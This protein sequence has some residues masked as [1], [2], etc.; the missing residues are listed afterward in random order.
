MSI[1]NDDIIQFNSTTIMN[2]DDE[3]NLSNSWIWK[4]NTTYRINSNR[5]HSHTYTHL[6]CQPKLSIHLSFIIKTF[7]TLMMIM[8]QLYN[9][10]NNCWSNDNHLFFWPIFNRFSIEEKRKEKSWKKSFLRLTFLS[11]V[12]MMIVWK[13]IKVAL[14]VV[15]VSYFA[16]HP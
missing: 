12:M 5:T 9:Q 10:N 1:S 11:M 16:I 6:N 3:F 7:I 14:V 2:D 8:Y 13:K 4:E 15:V